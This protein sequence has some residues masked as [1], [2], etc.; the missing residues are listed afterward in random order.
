MFHQ[1]NVIAGSG[2]PGSP[3][4]LAH[5][6]QVVMEELTSLLAFPVMVRLLYSNGHTHVQRTYLHTCVYALQPSSNSH[7]IFIMLNVHNS[8]STH[9]WHIPLSVASVPALRHGGTLCGQT[10]IYTSIFNVF[11]YVQRMNIPGMFNVHM[12]TAYMCST[13]ICSTCICSTSIFHGV[14]VLRM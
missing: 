5:W 6:Y 13:C 14:Q 12:F 2:L 1:A 9:T 4:L 3:S 11:I 8:C 7:I 10:Y